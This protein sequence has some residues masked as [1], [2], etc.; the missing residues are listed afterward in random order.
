M[1]LRISEVVQKARKMIS[2]PLILEEIA[3]NRKMFCRMFCAAACLMLLAVAPFFSPSADAGD[4]TPLPGEGKQVW[5]GKDYY[6][7]YSFNQKPSL[8]TVILKVEVYD[9]NGKKDTSLQISGDSGMPSMAGHHDTGNVALK[10]NKKG[11]YLL[12]VNVVM[13]GDWEVRLTFRKD[14]KP[15]FQGSISFYV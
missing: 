3:M 6:F 8:G 15:I 7:V 2:Y 4:Y 10:Q 5:I 12:P 1:R 13:P 9:R 11:D 14:D